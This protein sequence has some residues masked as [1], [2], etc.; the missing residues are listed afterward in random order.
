MENKEKSKNIE[1]ERNGFENFDGPG[2]CL[3][4]GYDIE[5][6]VNRYGKISWR[7]FIVSIILVGVGVIF[8]WILMENI[9]K[10]TY[11]LIM[12][13]ISIVCYM[14]SYIYARRGYDIMETRI[15]KDMNFI[16]IIFPILTAVV[17]GYFLALAYII[18]VFSGFSPYPQEPF[19]EWFLR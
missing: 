18:W 3:D 9:W 4:I 8:P 5:K 16:H 7:F 17:V 10:H 15:T 1:I 2:K 6:K 19:W 14:V 11:M 12:M 13:S